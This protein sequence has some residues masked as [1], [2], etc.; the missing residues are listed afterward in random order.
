MRRIGYAALSTMLASAIEN[1]LKTLLR[2]AGESLT[3]RADWRC[4]GCTFSRHTGKGF[5]Q[6][7]CYADVRLV[8][9]LSNAFKH[10][11]CRAGKELAGRLGIAQG[12]AVDYAAQDWDRLFDKAEAFVADIASELGLVGAPRGWTT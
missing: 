6:L 3:D 4:L 11:S 8:S 5:A 9:S 12:D 1:H 2:M 10:N 7:G